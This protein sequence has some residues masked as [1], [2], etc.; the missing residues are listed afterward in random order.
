MN[1]NEIDAARAL[2]EKYNA[3]MASE[4]KRGRKWIVD[5]S[6]GMRLVSTRGGDAGEQP[7]FFDDGK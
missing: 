2:A 1:R 7:E 6:G 5:L 4:G 3:R